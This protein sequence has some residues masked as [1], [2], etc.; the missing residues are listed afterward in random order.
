VTYNEL[1]IVEV[2]EGLDSLEVTVDVADEK[3]ERERQEVVVEHKTKV[4]KVL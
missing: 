4:V 2:G 3:Y 1:R